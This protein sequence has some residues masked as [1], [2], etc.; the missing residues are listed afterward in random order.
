MVQQKLLFTW[1]LVAGHIMSQFHF[2]FIVNITNFLSLYLKINQ[3]PNELK[4]HQTEPI[5]VN[6]DKSRQSIS[7]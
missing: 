2:F 4:S 6:Q 7:K 3:Y 1:F 5:K